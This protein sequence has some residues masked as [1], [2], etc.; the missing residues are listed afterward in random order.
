MESLLTTPDHVINVM[1]AGT[2]MRFLTAYFAITGQRKLLTGTPRMKERPIHLLVDALRTLGVTISYRE[3]EGYPPIE[4]YGFEKQL[5]DTI[6]IRGDVSSQ[7][8]SALMM[9]G[10]SLPGG[11]TIL[12]EGKTG[13]LPYLMMTAELM[14]LFGI[15]PE[16]SGNR[17]RI[18][19][20]QYTPAAYRVE[21]DWSAASYWFAITALAKEATILLPGVQSKA[22]QG[23]RVIVDIMDR[24]G[25][26][27]S[28]RAEGL[29]LT[30]KA[31]QVS[32]LEWDFS[33][34]PDLAQTVLPVCVAL[35]IQGKF[36]GLESLRIKETDR[37]AALQ[38][39]FG[40]IGAS[41]TE[42][43]GGWALLPGQ[44]LSEFKTISISTYHDH[45][46]AMG[47][48]PW[49]TQ[50]PVIIDSP[51]VVVKS[52]PTFWDDLKALGF[53]VESN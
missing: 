51:D 22:L 52:Y 1:D 46:M 20:G 8:I 16:V 19:S 23:D 44:S 6:S 3:K 38:T 31:V 33:N 7:F 13:S 11:L 28:F 48:A 9:A 30:K 42:Q 21:P 25:V 26:D 12:L 53:T 14:G 39:E 37:I 15:K 27:A 2:T 10:P 45:R 49:A 35:N 36:T 50:I 24:L 43:N 5:S 32:T 29:H 41:L 40:K 18:P 17:I 47:F 4:I 34:C